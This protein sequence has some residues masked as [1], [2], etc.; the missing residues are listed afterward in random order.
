MA[1]ISFATHGA[2]DA[3]TAADGMR[4]VVAPAPAFAEIVRAYAEAIAWE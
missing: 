3:C 1:A 2:H 4:R